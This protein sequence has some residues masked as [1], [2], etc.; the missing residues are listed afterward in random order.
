MKKKMKKERKWVAHDHPHWLGSHPFS[1]FFC[2]RVKY[3]FAPCD[4]TP[5]FFAPYDSFRI[6]DCTLV[7]AKD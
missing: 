7:L 2:F 3:A 4:L 5:L 1:F 6:V